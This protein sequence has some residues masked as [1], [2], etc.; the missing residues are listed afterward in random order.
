[1][2]FKT[3]GR[4]VDC[5]TSVRSLSDV[6]G[7]GE[8]GVGSV[9]FCLHVPTAPSQRCHEAAERSRPLVP[10]LRYL[11]YSHPSGTVEREAEHDMTHIYFQQREQEVGRV[12]QQADSGAAE[13]TLRLAAV[14]ILPCDCKYLLTRSE[15]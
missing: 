8:W 5:K 9:L 10:L 3:A 2:Q 4:K 11:L 14:A 1:M 15:R 6:S 7:G 12:E 13:G